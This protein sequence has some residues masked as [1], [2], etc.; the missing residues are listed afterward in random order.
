VHRMV[1]AVRASPI[2][3]ARHVTLRLKRALRRIVLFALKSRAGRWSAP[4]LGRVRFGDFGRTRPSRFW[5]RPWAR[6]PLRY[7]GVPATYCRDIFR[8]AP[9]R[10]ANACAQIRDRV[11]RRGH[12]SRAAD[13]PGATIV[14]R[15]FVLASPDALFRLFSRYTDFC[16]IYDMQAAVAAMHRALKPGGV[17]L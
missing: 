15:P 13:N 5:L 3:T 17:L 7:R 11:V 6:G 16:M 2:L 8:A 4:P 9:W 1:D 14:R 12:A 10:S